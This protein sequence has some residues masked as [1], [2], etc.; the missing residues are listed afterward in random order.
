MENEEFYK[1]T[2]AIEYPGD[3]ER[4]LKHLDPG[5][6]GYANT[7]TLRILNEQ[8]S[9]EKA[10]PQY[11]KK[12]FEHRQALTEQRIASVAL[13]PAK[14]LL[15]KQDSL[16]ESGLQDWHSKKEEK[17]AR[18]AFVKALIA[19]FGSVAKAWRLALDPQLKYAIEN[20]D[21]LMKGLKRAGQVPEGGEVGLRRAAERIFQACRSS[22]TEQISLEQL[23]PKT[24]AM[25][26]GFKDGCEERFGSLQDAFESVDTEGVGIISREDF[27]LLC[28]EVKATD[29][30]FRLM[31]FL[32]PKRSGEIRLALIDAEVTEDAM[33]A[34]KTRRE[35]ERQKHNSAQSGPRRETAAQ[36]CLEISKIIKDLSIYI[37]III[38]YQYI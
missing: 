6:A 24:P 7:R 30:I 36:E 26:E 10:V 19:K 17:S 11:L 2:D 15:A 8:K 9:E 18:E 20:V 14:E 32:D 37:S 25:M 27:R 31:E 22:E 29:G 38:K 13:P 35:L 23:D 33:L 4:L 21:Q 28:H 12:Y 16:R 3:P 34:T 1:V 5:S